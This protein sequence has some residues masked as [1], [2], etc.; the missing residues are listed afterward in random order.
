MEDKGVMKASEP[1]VTYPMTSYA[2]A[3]AMIHTMHLSREDKERVGRRLVLETTEESLSKAFDRLEQMSM[4]GAGWAGEGTLPVSR[5]AI[6]NLK[7]V[8]LISN[9]EDWENWMISPESNGAICLQ[10]KVRRSSISVGSEE[11]SYYTKINGQ[12]KGESHVCFDAD[13]FLS[14]MREISSDIILQ[15]VRWELLELA[16]LQS[17]QL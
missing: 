12:R 13:R 3:M 10:S 14:I 11:F 7:N 16:E 15:D 4:L 9:D 2:D 6:N 17:I 5:Q 8:L 1:A